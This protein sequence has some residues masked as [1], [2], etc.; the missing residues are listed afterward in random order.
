MSDEIGVH[1]RTQSFYAIEL[2]WQIRVE[3]ER[4]LARQAA[5]ADPKK[6]EALRALV[7]FASAA[8]RLSS[9]WDKLDDTS[10][11]EA[12]YPKGL[13]SFDEFAD[14]VQQWR[15]KAKAAAR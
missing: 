5:A 14:Q 4:A 10:F 11:L 15:D 9:V 12:G 2:I 3:F 13:P 8:S 6:A 7:E 1:R